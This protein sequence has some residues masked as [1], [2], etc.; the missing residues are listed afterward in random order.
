MR[1]AKKKRKVT[2]KETRALPFVVGALVLLG[3]VTV[4]RMLVGNEETKKEPAEPRIVQKTVRKVPKQQKQ[5]PVE[6]HLAPDEETDE[7]QQPQPQQPVVRPDTPKSEKGSSSEPEHVADVRTPQAES[8]TEPRDEEIPQVDV[9]ETEE[10]DEPTKEQE[11]AEEEEKHEPRRNVRYHPVRCSN[12]VYSLS[13]AAR[14]GDVELVRKRL[15]EGYP[16]CIRNEAGMT[17]LHLAVQ[18]GRTAAARLLISRGADVLAKDKQGRLPIDLTEN[19]EI[20]ALLKEAEKVRTKELEVFADIKRGETKKLQEMLAHGMSPDVISEDG[21]TCIL[22]EA[23][24]SRNN[25]AVRILLKAG[26][27]LSTKGVGGKTALHIAAGNGD[28]ETTQLLLKAG[29]DPMT[30][31]GNGATPL[32]E[33]IWSGK[34]ETVKLLLPLY[35]KINFSPMYSGGVGPPIAM[36]IYHGREA[37]VQEMLKAGLKV[38]SPMFEEPLLVTAVKKGNVEIVKMLLKAHARKDAKDS[39]GKVAADY[40]SGEVARLLK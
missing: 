36:A 31:G 23:V 27:K 39:Q 30:P 37:V 5:Q 14:A 19:E 2:K 24:C 40:A 35:K 10:P 33:A 13:E 22:I 28:V 17:P 4:G 8:D 7:P 32:H 12:S 15:K 25:E 38:N 20:K 3:A 9:R 18:N 29:A 1:R 34:L 21:T 11:V 26:A 6:I 16:V